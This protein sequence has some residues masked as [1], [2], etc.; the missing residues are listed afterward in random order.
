MS[1][2]DVEMTTAPVVPAQRGDGCPEQQERPQ[3][4]SL[5][6]TIRQKWFSKDGG[7]KY[8]HDLEFCFLR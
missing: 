8:R 7:E 1:D 5:T 4:R 2:Y 6:S 3:K